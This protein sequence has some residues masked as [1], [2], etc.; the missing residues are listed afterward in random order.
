[1]DNIFQFKSKS[2]RTA[3][4]NMSEFIR[5][6]RD[7]LTVFGV[8]LNWNSHIW[9]NVAVFSQFGV[10]TRKPNPDQIM[11]EK[12]IDFAKAY[13]R[14]QQGHNPTG[15]KNEL[16]ALR[17]IELSLKEYTGSCN[18]QEI[19]ISVLN[20]AIEV[21][22]PHYSVGAV[23]QCGRELEKLA[24][25]LTKNKLV[26]TKLDSWKNPIKRPN[27]TVRTGLKGKQE[28]EKKLPSE[29]ALNAMAEIFSRSP[30]KPRDI[31]T[32]SI[33]AILMSAPS[34]ISEVLSLPVDC[35][36]TEKDKNGIERYGLRFFSG[37]GYDGDIK[38]IPTTMVEIAKEAIKRVRE[39]TEP[40]RKFAKWAEM[41]PLEFYN[42]DDSIN[43]NNKK[44]L[45]IKEICYFLGVTYH[46]SN[47]LS[48][49]RSKGFITENG[50]YCLDTLWPVIMKNLPQ[51][52][53]WYDEKL[54][55]KYSNALFCMN[56]N[57]LHETRMSIPHSLFK[58]DN[59]FFSNDISSKTHVGDT[60]KNIFVR[61]GYIGEN[62]EPIVLRSHQAR[63][64]LNTIAQRGGLSN[65]EI[66]KWS[67]R[68][69]VKQNRVYN[70]M[71]EFEMVKIAE[72]VDIT[73]NKHSIISDVINE[74]L[75][76]TTQQ[77]NLL[78]T[79]AAHVTEYG[80]CVHDYT[81]SPCN[82]FRDC[83]NCSEQVCIKGDKLKLERIKERE[84]KINKLYN[85]AISNKDDYYGEDRWIEYH[86][87]TL[88]RLR[89]LISIMENPDIADNAQIKLRGKD[90]SQLS[91]VMNK[92][93]E[94][95]LDDKKK[96]D[97][98]DML[99]DIRAIMGN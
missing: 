65:L 70:H 14:Y 47:S 15:T 34:R 67:G 69:D 36:Y 13:F 16:K 84:N 33:F 73:A 48:F 25:F 35:E 45:S 30:D 92:E 20:K 98:N 60:R 38:W 85:N 63:H 9:P 61:N 6:C 37:K 44:P 88:E 10:T 11:D 62:G 83:I 72:L 95:Q 32:S 19:N 29:E 81:M 21:A 64:L 49:L 5:K 7:E 80:Y 18:A 53:P 1:M 77:F 89:E 52:F 3:E 94:P 42:L 74:N 8:D 82:K 50:H 57:Q 23:Y 17:A 96:Q 12:F 55:I 43:I 39:L 93:K 22:K 78:E 99:S 54:K 56:E 75:P 59:T 86:K 87:K 46:K 31:F 24:K 68:A 51:D 28:R 2:H 91:K 76:I 90:F 40:A 79:G 58:P 4:E 27:D 71:T 41:H 97:E 66:A 26:P